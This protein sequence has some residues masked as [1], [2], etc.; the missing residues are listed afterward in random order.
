[1]TQHLSVEVGVLRE[2]RVQSDQILP[3]LCQQFEHIGA[4]QRMFTVQFFQFLVKADLVDIGSVGFLHLHLRF[5]QETP[6]EVDDEVEQRNDMRVSDSH[7]QLQQFEEV[8][9]MHLLEKG[10]LN[11]TVAACEPNEHRFKV[12]S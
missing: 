3:L 12:I 1:M 10:S 2:G 6:H 9:T 5:W 8:H 4:V 11:D 7:L